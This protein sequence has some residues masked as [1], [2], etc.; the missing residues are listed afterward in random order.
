MW[1][2]LTKALSPLALVILISSK[3][4][5]V[6]IYFVSRLFSRNSSIINTL[7]K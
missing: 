6:S 2:S 1:L 3:A 5:I 4:L 7:L